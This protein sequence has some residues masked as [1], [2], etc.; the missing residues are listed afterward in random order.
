MS[1]AK[2]SQCSLF[3]SETLH[4]VAGYRHDQV[5]P[6]QRGLYTRRVELFN[7]GARENGWPDAGYYDWYSDYEVEHFDRQLVRYWL[8][9]RPLY[10]QLHAYVRHRLRLVYPNAFG[11]RDPIPV[12]LLRALLLNSFTVHFECSNVH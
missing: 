10:E 8:E 2:C 12:H 5:G 7:K 1:T 4:V 3:T 9:I 6:P 11:E